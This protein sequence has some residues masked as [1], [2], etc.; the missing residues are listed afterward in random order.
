[1]LKVLFNKIQFG[2]WLNILQG[3]VAGMHQ[4]QTEANK[5][6]WMQ[7]QILSLLNVDVKDYKATLYTWTLHALPGLWACDQEH[8]Y[9]IF[10]S[11]QWN[12]SVVHFSTFLNS[13]CTYEA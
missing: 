3:P 12:I 6:L 2:H 13:H 9:F 7:K 10:P 4:V 5:Y 8:K 11:M 1:M